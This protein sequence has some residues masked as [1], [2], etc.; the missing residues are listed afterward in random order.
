MPRSSILIALVSVATMGV[1]APSFAQEITDCDRL[2]AGP[3]DGGRIA[4]GVE[5][6]DMDAEAAQA[7]CRYQRAASTRSSGTPK[8]YSYW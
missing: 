1:S 2:A 3:A 8:P 7:A 6:P 5:Q 4:E